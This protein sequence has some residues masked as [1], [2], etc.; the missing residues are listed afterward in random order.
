MKPRAARPRIT[1]GICYET[2][3]LPNRL[4][5]WQWARWPPLFRF[6]LTAGM[7]E[8]KPNSTMPLA[9]GPE[10]ILLVADTKGAAVTAIATGDTASAK[11][12]KPLKVEGINQKI[13][14]LL[15][16]SADQIMIN[17][18][19]VNPISRNAYL[20]VSRGRGPEAVPVL[21]KV[22]S[23]GDLEAVSLDQVKFSRGELPDAPVDGVVG[24]GDRQSNPRQESI[25]DIAFFQDRDARIIE[26]G[27][28]LHAARDSF[29]FEKVA[30]GTSEI[31]MGAWPVR[32]PFARAPS[33]RSTSGR[34][35]DCAYTAHRWCSIKELSPGAKSLQDHRRTRKPQ[36]SA[37]HDHLSK[38]W[39]GLLLLAN[40]SHG[41]MKIS[42]DNIERPRDRKVGTRK[43]R[44]T[45]PLSLTGGSTRQARSNALV[46]R[47][48]KAPLNLNRRRREVPPVS[49]CMVLLASL[50]AL[51]GERR[52]F[53][54]PDSCE[55]G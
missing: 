53:R 41:I 54:R 21:V 51:S 26:R 11:D 50:P 37:R 28:R 5:C 3:D 20:A 2:N 19:V 14:G 12:A 42:T 15:G 44:A 47:R 38:G 27:I 23:S 48:G 39:Q 55:P 4:T 33:C 45:K 8:G 25:T 40:S 49:G 36:S 22:K 52:L 34:A 17:D 31:F 43:A 18:M 9:F 1:Y 46:V 29:P 7:K 30:N 32:N 13:A 16:T 24:Q 10:G 35:V 6:Q